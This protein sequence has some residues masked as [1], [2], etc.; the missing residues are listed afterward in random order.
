[1]SR[2]RRI[3]NK[4][5]APAHN[6]PARQQA[7]RLGTPPRRR[8]RQRTLAKVTIRREVA[9]AGV[10]AP[11]DR[12]KPSRRSRASQAELRGE[13]GAELR[14]G[15]SRAAAAAAAK[16]P[17]QG[18]QLSLISRQWFCLLANGRR[19]AR[20]RRRP[21]FR[22]RCSAQS[23]PL[24]ELESA[25]DRLEGSSWQQRREVAACGQI[26]P[27][28]PLAPPPPSLPANARGRPPVCDVSPDDKS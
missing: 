4:S 12:A 10:G 11:A 22:Y 6:G 27:A 17:G 23:R 18:I 14:A 20:W 3:G 9:P 26:A 13:L 21:S 2:P 8:G 1:M 15:D 24:S 19:A 5:S 28:T 16:A 25:Y 7:S